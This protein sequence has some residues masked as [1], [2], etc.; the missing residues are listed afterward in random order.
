MRTDY[1]KLY[2][3][4][5][6]QNFPAGETQALQV[7]EQALQGGITCFQLREKGDTALTG[8]ASIRFAQKCQVLCHRY[9]VPFIVNDNIELALQLDADGIHVGQ[10]D[11]AVSSFKNKFPNKIIGLSVHTLSELELAVQ[12][13]VNYVGI[14]PI[15]ATASKND[16]KKP[17]GVD[18]ITEAKRHCPTMPIVAI[19]G[20][21][22]DNAASVLAHGADG[23]SVISAISAANDP[24]AATRQFHHL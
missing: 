12:Q 6:S 22:L 16:A 24:Q 7:L 19:G 3:I 20:I 4:M 14:G 10:D 2:F 8:A 5:G 13:D 15:F 23:L 21:T 1:L 18:F 17:C 11:A 9:Q